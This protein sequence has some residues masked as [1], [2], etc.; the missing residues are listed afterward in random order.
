MADLRA[1]E[2]GPLVLGQTEAHGAEKNYLLPVIS[3]CGLWTPNYL[4]RSHTGIKMF[5][6]NM[7]MLLVL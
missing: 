1:K 5:C 7:H 4:K 3:G 6:V 2:P